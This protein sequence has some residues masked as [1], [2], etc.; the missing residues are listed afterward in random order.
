V[1][2]DPADVDMDL[3]HGFLTEAYWATGTTRE[4]VRRSVDGSIPFSLFEDDTQVGFARV[5][6]DRATFAYVSDVF[7][8]ADAR[9]RGLGS[10]LV[11]SMLAHPDLQGLRRWTL[12]TRDAH[13]LYARFGFT[14]PTQPERL[15]ELRPTRPPTPPAPIS[16]PTEA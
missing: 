16:D 2:T 12:A 3:V 10:F 4:Q 11:E 8:V 7:V 13:P 9:G 15:M 1:S 14:A 5:I 6:S